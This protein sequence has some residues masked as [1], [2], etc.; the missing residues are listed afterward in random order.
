[1][2]PAFQRVV[3]YPAVLAGSGSVAAAGGIVLTVRQAVQTKLNEDN[4]LLVSGEGAGPCHTH[5]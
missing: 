2:S 4:F 3:V 1:M 5:R